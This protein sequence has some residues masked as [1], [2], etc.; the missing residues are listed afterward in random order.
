MADSV[1]PG[2]RGYL[3]LEDLRGNAGRRRREST[4]RRVFFTAAAFSIVISLAI[5]VSLA[6]GAVDFFSKIDGI[7]ELW[8]PRGWFPRRGLFDILTI[9]LG[10]TLVALVAIAVAAPI[11]LGAAMYLSEYASRRT[12]RYLK[13][14]VEVLAGIP[15]VV[16]GFFALTFISP[17]FVQALVPGT[18]AFNMAAAGIGV[19][20]LI[21]PLVATVAEDAMHAVPGALREASFGLGAKKRTTSLRVVFPAAV[22]GIV[23]ALIL[24]LSRAIGETLVVSIAAGAVGGSDRT[25]NIFGPGQ[26]MTAAMTSL[27]T[28]SDQVRGVGAAYP[29]LF[30][31]GLLL[32]GMTLLLNLASERFVRRVR[33]QL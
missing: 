6:G 29:S 22:S 15:S 17:N 23:A 27:A 18:P 16:M 25:L 9:V 12:R 20:I 33:R 13:P 11:G 30:F 14:I 31:V 4:I 2:V 26:T 7:G 1:R 28:G 24:G 5:V 19:G 10:T 3:G 21:I 8:N 32:F